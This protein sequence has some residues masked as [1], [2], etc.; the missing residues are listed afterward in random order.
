MNDFLKPL[1]GVNPM[2][3]V[4]C[5]ETVIVVLAMAIDFASG[6]YK[7][8]LRGEV[9]SSLGMKR[10]ISKF[11][12]YV[13]SILI[14]CGI[15]SIFYICGFW[16]IIHFTTL[17]KVPVVTTIISVFICAVEIRSV[18]ESADAKQKR[19]AL[20]TAEALIQLIGKENLADRLEELVNTVKASKS[21]IQDSK[22][23]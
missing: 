9:R 5:I 11:I 16:E 22:I 20:E 6:L 18:W 14:G 1:D 15:D 3:T 23:Q 21:D 7:A 10:T 4:V 13:G 8:K 2:W 17:L 12:L 19:V